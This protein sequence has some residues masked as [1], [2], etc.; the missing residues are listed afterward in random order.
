M[1]LTMFFTFLFTMAMATE[2]PP[3]TIVI[4]ND[5]AVVGTV[6]LPSRPESVRTALSDPTFLPTTT[7][8]TTEVRLTRRDGPCQIIDSISPSTF[9]TARYRTRRCRT[10]SGYRSTLV[11]SNCFKTYETS[12][13]LVP[14]PHGTTATYRIQAT[15]S[16]W[17]PNGVIRGQTKNA[18][19]DLLPKLQA[20]FQKYPGIA[21]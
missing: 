8:S 5:G 6:E 21:P 13:T 18:M 2:L 15:T 9:L 1:G 4:Q 10:P 7:G 17:I 19:Q 14:S 16:L 20:H 12:W 11:S 3:P